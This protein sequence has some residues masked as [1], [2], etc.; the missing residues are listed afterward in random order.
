MFTPLKLTTEEGHILWSEKSPCSPNACRPVMIF[1][2]KEI[3]ENIQIVMKI[4]DEK[5]NLDNFTIE[6]DNHQFEIHV[7]G[8]FCMLDGKMRK[9][10]SGL[11]GAWCLL[12]TC[13]RLEASGLCPE[14]GIDRVKA[15]F[16]IN[17]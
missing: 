5:Q 9:L 15:G 16:I 11:G 12:C 3:L 10:V 13:T 7:D 17:R 8:N 4:Q 6:I 14:N 1:L 2:G